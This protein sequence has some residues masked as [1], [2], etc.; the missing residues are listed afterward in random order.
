MRY[1]TKAIFPFI[2][3]R[4]TLQNAQKESN[5]INGKRKKQLQILTYSATQ[6]V[7]RITKLFHLP[8]R[9]KQNEISTIKNIHMTSRYRETKKKL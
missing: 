7:S 4:F 2:I 5:T 3:S 8:T 9:I 1:T 6:F